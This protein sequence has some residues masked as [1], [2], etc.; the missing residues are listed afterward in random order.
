VLERLADIRRAIAGE[1]TDADGV[2]AVRA[3]LARLFKGFVIH[4]PADTLKAVARSGEALMVGPEGREE[5]ALEPVLRDEVLA[6][7]DGQGF[8]QLRREPLGQAENNYLSSW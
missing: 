3:A 1:I 6:G 7:F 2:D 4:P 8:P 5:F